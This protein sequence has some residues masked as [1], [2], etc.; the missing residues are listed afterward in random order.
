[1]MTRRRIGRDEKCVRGVRSEALVICCGMAMV[2]V[3]SGWKCGGGGDCAVSGGDA[4]VV[5]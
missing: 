5:W 2:M 4:G 3:L 1:M